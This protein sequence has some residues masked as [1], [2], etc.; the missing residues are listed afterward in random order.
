MSEEERTKFYSDHDF[1]IHRARQLLGEEDAV[2]TE[3][4]D[5]QFIYDGAEFLW[6][7]IDDR[8]TAIRWD[9]VESY[10]VS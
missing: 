8:P 2:I 5:T 1:D 4:S 6:V 9:F 10:R 3:E 7:E